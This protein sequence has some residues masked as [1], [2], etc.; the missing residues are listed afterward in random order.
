MPQ[1]SACP[2]KQS[3][4]N[5]DNLCKDCHMVST[6]NVIA[7]EDV[8]ND[9]V[10][11]VSSQDIVNLPNLPDNWLSEPIQNLNGGH[12]LKIFLLGT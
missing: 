12:I 8:E 4:L 5:P 6:G 7:T 9:V 3:I 10:P 11:G 1:C 2:K